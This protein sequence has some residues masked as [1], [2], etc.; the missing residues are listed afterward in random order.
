MFQ[1]ITIIALLALALSSSTGLAQVPLFPASF[2]ARDIPSNGT[3]LHVRIG[4]SGPAVVLLH[5]FGDT[6]DIW[7]PLAAN[8]VRDH[9]VIVPDLRC[10][11]ASARPARV[12]KEL[13][14]LPT[15]S[16]IKALTTLR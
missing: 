15:A 12:A 1:R 4:G 8:L 10:F 5:G 11:G 7:A 16:C 6:G 13:R 3:A 14:W 9:T 2:T